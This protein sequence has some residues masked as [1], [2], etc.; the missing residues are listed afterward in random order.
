MDLDPSGFGAIAQRRT[1]WRN[2][3]RPVMARLEA[4]QHQQRLI[5][6]AAPFGVQV[7]DQN[8][9]EFATPMRR[10]EAINL[11][12]LVYFNRTDRAAIWEIKAPR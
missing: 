5:L 12:S 6:A 2:Q 7:N 8:L 11:P 9:H 10:F 4:L 1:L 3:F